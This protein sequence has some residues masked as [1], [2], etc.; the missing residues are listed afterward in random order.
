MRCS[1][2]KVLVGMEFLWTRRGSNG[3]DFFE[4]DGDVFDNDGDIIDSF[5]ADDFRL[6]FSF[7]YNFDIALGG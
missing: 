5:T 6:Q 4:N 7:K 1:Q 2:E 3:D